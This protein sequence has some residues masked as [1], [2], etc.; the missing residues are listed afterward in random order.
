MDQRDTD[1][2]CDLH[3]PAGDPGC[4]EQKNPI[5]TLQK[6]YSDNSIEIEDSPCP[7]KWSQT[8]EV[9]LLRT[10]IT[11]LREPIPSVV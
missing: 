2:P 11:I 1:T 3:E 9:V 10:I 5:E 4:M 8:T 7:T 6:G